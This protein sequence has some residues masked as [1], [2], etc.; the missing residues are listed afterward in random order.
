MNIQFNYFRAVSKDV[1]ILNEIGL[2][3]GIDHCS[4]IDLLSRL[5]SQNKEIRSFISFCGGL[6]APETSQV[7]LRYKFSW[8]PAGVLSAALREAQYKLDSYVR[9]SPIKLKSTERLNFFSQIYHVPG[10]KLLKSS[11]P[12]VPITPEFDLEGLPNGNSLRYA[13]TYDIVAPTVLR[14]T[15]R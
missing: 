1:L 11:F 13:R 10:D 4:A 3:P 6:P 12:N 14:G 5:K 8:S 15:L 7:P 2:D 9:C